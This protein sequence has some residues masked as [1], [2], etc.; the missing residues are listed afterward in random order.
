[1]MEKILVRGLFIVSS[2]M[3]VSRFL[4]GDHSLLALIIWLGSCVLLYRLESSKF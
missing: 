4:M 3:L 1:M 2:I